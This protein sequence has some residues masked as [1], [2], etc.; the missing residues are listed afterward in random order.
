MSAQ[1]LPA[2]R[3]LQGELIK[4]AVLS[5]WEMGYMNFAR[6]EFQRL[7]FLIHQFVLPAL[8]KYENP[9]C[10]EIARHLEKVR[11]F[12]GNFCWRHSALGASHDARE[13]RS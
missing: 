4:D 2:T 5:D 12:S 3:T 1:S 6:E 10:C 8:G 13:V 7:D 11:S 9:L